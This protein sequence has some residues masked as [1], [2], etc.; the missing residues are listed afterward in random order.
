MTEEKIL[1]FLNID[2][3]SPVNKSLIKGMLCFD[4]GVSIYIFIA[5]FILE[6]IQGAL[7][8][9]IT[10]FF[11][12]IADI[13]FGIIIKRIKIPTQIYKN[14][15]IIMLISS[16]KLFYGAL[17]FSRIEDKGFGI[18]HFLVFF[19]CVSLA[20]WNILRRY[21]YF[22]DL[23]NL[24]IKETNNKWEKKNKG[25]GAFIFPISTTA[26]AA[27][28]LSRCISRTININMG[29]V[30]W[31]LACIWMFIMSLFLQ[32]HIISMRY[33]VSNI[34]SHKTGKTKTHGDGSV[35]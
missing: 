17:L 14:I 31:A 9:V 4:I 16:I 32:N 13:V 3:D 1:F 7:F 6:I 25:I 19:I 27:F 28:V 22:Q 2:A 24:S 15:C 29:F 20:F 35:C 8:K 33:E 21:R 12:V 23:K 11:F 30:C 34:F 5:D 10:I 18:P 26:V